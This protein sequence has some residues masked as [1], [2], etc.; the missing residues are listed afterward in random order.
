VTL[1]LTATSNNP[2]LIPNP[3]IA[4][5]SPAAIDTLS[6]TPAANQSGTATIIVTVT[7]NGSGGDSLLIEPRPSN[8]L[9]VRV[10]QTG[11]LLGIFSLTAF[12][13][14]VLF[15]LNGSDT[16]ASSDCGRPLCRLVRHRAVTRAFHALVWAN[17]CP[18]LDSTRHCHFD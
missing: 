6:Y 12:R 14:I 18:L 13:R 11:H 8:R 15:G 10:K 3:T 2:G 4:Y 9:Q 17:E 7:D 5:A 16:A 1:T